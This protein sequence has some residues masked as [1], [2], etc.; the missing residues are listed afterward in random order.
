MSADASGPG[1]NSLRIR[2]VGRVQGVGF[3]Y[4]CASIAKRYSVDGYVKNLADGAVELV[5]SGAVG[6]VRRFLAEIAQVF[7]HNIRDS[8]SETVPVAEPMRGFQIRR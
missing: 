3:R 4:T 5:V 1:T 7:E 6:E 2:Y 8:T